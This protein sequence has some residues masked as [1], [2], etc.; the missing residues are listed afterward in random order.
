MSTIITRLFQT[1]TP[2]TS[3]VAA[4]RKSGMR[5]ADISQVSSGGGDKADDINDLVNTIVE[6]GVPVSH[7]RVYA[8]LVRNGAALVTVRAPPMAALSTIQILKRFQPIE[9]SIAE[10]DVY[11]PAESVGLPTIL[12]WTPRTVLLD[13]DRYFFSFLGPLVIKNAKPWSS[14]NID[15]KPWSSAYAGAT[16]SSKLG[17]PTII[18]S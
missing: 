13:S 11:I 17:I 8:V 4:L 7:A 12:R 3:A 6:G 15:A 1:D 2:A 16:T 18:R 5:E 10:P 9:T 14:V